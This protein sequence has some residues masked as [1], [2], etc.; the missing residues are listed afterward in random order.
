[1]RL[2]TRT[3]GEGE[4]TTVLVHGIMSDSRTWQVVAP[5]IA[6]RGYRVVG[7]DLRGHGRS[8]RGRYSPQDWADDL[9]ETLPSGPDVAIGHSLGAVALALAVDRL[10]P[11]RAAYVDPA[12]FA[13]GGNGDVSA[14]RYERFRRFK[15]ATRDQIVQVHPRWDTEDV[16]VELAT[17]RDWDPDTVDGASLISGADLAPSQPLAPSLVLIAGESPYYRQEAVTE[18]RQRGLET[19]V[20]PD[21]GHTIHRDDPDA[22]LDSLQGWV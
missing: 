19:R 3:W 2:H 10:R 21:V 17:L 16:D 6:E 9:V 11:G 4:R 1:M 15:D 20:V 7:V 18:M 5:R 12:W 22:F 14:D 13:G 8:G